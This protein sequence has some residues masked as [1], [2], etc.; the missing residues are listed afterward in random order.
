MS[1]IK[2]KIE[3]FGDKIINDKENNDEKSMEYKIDSMKNLDISVI[4]DGNLEPC[5]ELYNELMG[6]QKSKAHIKRELFDKFNF[7]ESMKPTY[8]KAMDSQ[9]LLAKDNGIPIGYVFSTIILTDDMKKASLPGLLP[10]WSDLPA[11]IAHLNKFFIKDDY[12]GSGLGSKMIQ[13]AE[14]WMFGF[15]DVDLIFVHVSNGNEEGYDFYIK[16]GFIFSHEVMG[17]FIKA[18]YKYR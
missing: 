15:S 13:M 14:D 4:K 1:K 11:K 9:I 17:G 12:R 6:F 7:D 16:H 5:R 18:V 10:E 3:I 8:E 2:N